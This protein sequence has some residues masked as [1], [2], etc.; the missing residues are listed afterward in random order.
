MEKKFS[1]EKIILFRIHFLL[2]LCDP[3]CIIR[4]QKYSHDTQKQNVRIPILTNRWNFTSTK[5]VWTQIFW[6]EG[7]KNTSKIR[8][9]AWNLSAKQFYVSVLSW[10][11]RNKFRLNLYSYRTY[12]TNLTLT[13]LI[14]NLLVHE[15]TR[16][17]LHSAKFSKNTADSCGSNW[18]WEQ[19][20][21][22][23]K[24]KPRPILD[25]VIEDADA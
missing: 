1:V 7:D 22:F 16:L 12:H 13:A 10:L 24:Y 19:K 20:Q 5:Y 21:I 3:C 23:V 4:S 18:N 25:L 2:I 6:V 11:P 8:W 15:H 14:G 9:R 17:R